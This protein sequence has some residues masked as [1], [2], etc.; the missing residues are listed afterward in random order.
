MRTTIRSSSMAVGLAA[1]LAIPAVASAQTFYSIASGTEATYPGLRY[2]SVQGSIGRRISP[3]LEARVEAFVS[4]W[5]E[6]SHFTGHAMCA[7]PIVDCNR[8]GPSHNPGGVGGLAGNALL[9]IAPPL[10]DDPR[11]Y[12]IGGVGAYFLPQMRMGLS[13]GVGCSLPIAP[14]IRVVLEARYHFLFPLNMLFPLN[15]TFVGTTHLIPVTLGVR[16]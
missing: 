11:A 3:R 10:H 8:L 14:Q 2:Y 1:L 4:H 12:L 6:V 13:A 15:S 16:F 7:D 5:D 9:Y